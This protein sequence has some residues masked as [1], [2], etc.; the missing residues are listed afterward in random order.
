MSATTALAKAARRLARLGYTDIQRYGT[1]GLSAVYGPWR[2][3]FYSVQVL[4]REAR[5]V[6]HFRSRRGCR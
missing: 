1:G 4:Q 5:K 6:R 3:H 2:W